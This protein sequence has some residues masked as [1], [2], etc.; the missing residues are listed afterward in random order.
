MYIYGG[1]IAL[2]DVILTLLSF[3]VIIFSVYN[4]YNHDL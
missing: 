1:I 4:K 2:E 3:P